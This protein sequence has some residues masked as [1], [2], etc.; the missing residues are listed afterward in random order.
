[1][2]GTTVCN[3]RNTMDGEYLDKHV[4]CAHAVILRRHATQVWRKGCTFNTAFAMMLQICLCVHW[5]VAFG[6]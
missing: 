5:P 4:V 2:P 6:G 3:M 1:M